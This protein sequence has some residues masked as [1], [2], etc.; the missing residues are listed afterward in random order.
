[1]VLLF[2]A[3]GFE[4]VEALTAV[5]FLRRGNVEVKTVGVGGKEICGAHGIWVVADLTEQEVSAEGLEMLVLP[6]GSGAWVLEKSEK[7]QQLIAC[8]AKEELWLAAICAA[9]FILGHLGLISG[10]R[11]TCYP[12]FEQELIGAVYTGAPVETDGKVITGRG[13]G[14]ASE[15]ALALLRA[16]R[17][18]AVAMEVEAGLQRA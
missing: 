17:G 18:D 3:E 7:V 4:E 6:G 11:A 12:G 1:M 10:K 15:F 5:D 14:V 9:P 13:P 8:A 2:L 16:L